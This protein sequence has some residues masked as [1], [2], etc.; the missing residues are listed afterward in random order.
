MTDR[1]AQNNSSPG[2]PVEFQTTRWSIV[3]AATDTDRETSS[4]A[5]AELYRTYWRPLYVFLRRGGRSATDSQDLIQELFVHLME[6]NVLAYVDPQRGRFRSFLLA[7]LKQQLA[8][9]HRREA[10]DKRGGGREA[11]SLDFDKEESLCRHEPADRLTPELAYERRWALALIESAVE[12]LREEYETRRKSVLFQEL[13]VFLR[14]A[15]PEV[16]YAE[17]AERLGSTEGA[18]RVAVHRLRR[19]C[20]E[21]VRQE[22]AHTVASPAEVDQELEYLLARLSQ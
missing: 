8:Q 16:S 22:I 21:L 1:R 12:R 9:Q 13:E 4:E 14:E 18:V 3:L 20:G 15:S 10:A 19:R 7:A 17:L 6:A 2:G 11:L 5:L